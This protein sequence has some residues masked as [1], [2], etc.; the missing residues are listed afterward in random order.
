MDRAVRNFMSFTGAGLAETVG[1]ATRNPARMTGLD[2]QIGTLA[3]GRSA[4]IAVLSAKNEVVET[5]LRGE[6]QLMS[7]GDAAFNG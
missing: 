4:D 2:E 5:F 1:L 7:S 3:P 6:P